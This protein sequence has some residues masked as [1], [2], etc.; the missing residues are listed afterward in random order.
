MFARDRF[1]N[2]LIFIENGSSIIKSTKFIVNKEHENSYIIYN[3]NATVEIG[4][5]EFENV[6]QKTVYNDNFLEIEKDME[7]YVESGKNGKPLKYK[8]N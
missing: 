1:N 6:D 3:E 5:L 8:S 7:K 2:N 4:K